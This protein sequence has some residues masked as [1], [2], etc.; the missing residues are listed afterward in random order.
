MR[1]QPS[2]RA[3]RSKREEQRRL[4]SV[5]ILAQRKSCYSDY[6]AQFAKARHLAGL[7]VDLTL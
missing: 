3:A 4:I 6:P 1:V 2:L 5:A 7:K